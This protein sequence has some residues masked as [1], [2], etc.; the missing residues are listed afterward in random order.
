MVTNFF[1]KYFGMTFTPLSSVND[2]TYFTERKNH[3]LMFRFN[4]KKSFSVNNIFVRNVHNFYTVIEK[5]AEENYW[6][7][8][9]ILVS[10]F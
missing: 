9:S 5:L 1:F 2:E 4:G 8:V 7:I 10:I 6:Y 3:I